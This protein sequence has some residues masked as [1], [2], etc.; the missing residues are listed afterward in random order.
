MHIWR[1]KSKVLMGSLTEFFTHKLRF[2]VSRHCYIMQR[3]IE[4]FASQKARGSLASDCAVLSPIILPQRI[5]N[6][7]LKHTEDVKQ[8]SIRMKITEL[9]N[10]FRLSRNRIIFKKFLLCAC[11]C[12]SW[13]EKTSM[14]S[15]CGNQKQIWSFSSDLLNVQSHYKLFS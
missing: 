15:V 7:A 9:T 2:F 5:W 8:A 4:H 13:Q 1:A 11:L 6:L 14:C 3:F 12:F 10:T